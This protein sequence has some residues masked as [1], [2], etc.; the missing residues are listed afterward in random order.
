M[1]PNTDTIETS[2]S[3]RMLELDQSANGWGTFSAFRLIGHVFITKYS[4]VRIPAA[5]VLDNQRYLSFL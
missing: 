1:K 2:H 4:C 5:V 3:V